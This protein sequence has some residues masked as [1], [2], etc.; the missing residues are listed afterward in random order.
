MAFFQLCVF[1]NFPSGM[2]SLESMC[3][4]LAEE[5][6]IE[7]TKQSLDER[8]NEKAVSFIKANLDDLIARQIQID[9]VFLEVMDHF[10]MIRIADSTSF[11]IPAHLYDAYQGSG[12]NGSASAIK[13]YYEYDLKSGRLI[14]LV[15]CS[16]KMNDTRFLDIAGGRHIEPGDLFIKDMGFYRFNYLEQIA[17]RGAYFISRFR[18]GTSIYVEEHGDL[19]K[20]AF[21]DLINEQLDQQ[22]L[23]VYLGEAKLAVRLIVERLPPQAY[24]Q[25]KRNANKTAKRKGKKITEQ[26]KKLMAYNIF[27]TN[28][29]EQIVPAQKIWKIYSSRWQIEIM[30]KVW[31]S[32]YQID[33]IG[34]MSLHR[35]QCMLYGSLIA[36]ILSGHIVHLFRF[37]LWNNK[38][39]ELSEW[40]A[41]KEIYRRLEKLGRALGKSHKATKDQ[42]KKIFK[43]IIQGGPKA[44]RKITQSDQYR[45][46]PMDIFSG[47]ENIVK[48]KNVA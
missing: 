19:K 26:K 39:I 14:N 47:S 17:E 4:Y 10:N 41:Y 11:Q 46:T 43:A 42:L 32:I 6:N 45:Q 48:G 34:K 20:V 27:I 29:P 9:P 37:Y 3:S 13:L 7:L 21:H 24:E 16:G 23:E 25:R 18:T 1:R 22:Q 33:K 15:D 44:K 28:I 8:F 38:K 40:K 5:H 30:F 2:T 36:I 35:Y 12:G 31:K